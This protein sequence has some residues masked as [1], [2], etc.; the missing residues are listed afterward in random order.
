M[1]K[2]KTHGPF[3][4]RLPP[5]RQQSARKKS[6]VLREKSAEPQ[7][8][9]GT[10]RTQIS[11]APLQ[12]PCTALARMLSFT[13]HLS[14]DRVHQVKAANPNT[15]LGFLHLPGKVYL[16]WQVNHQRTPMV[17]KHLQR[18]IL[19]AGLPLLIVEWPSFLHSSVLV[20]P[21]AG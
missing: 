6:C 18:P 4:L 12:V 3:E 17:C 19:C 13:F 20:T 10:A 21:V 14:E 7:L 2:S 15:K 11:R 5:R 8:T 9:I 1:G 16:H